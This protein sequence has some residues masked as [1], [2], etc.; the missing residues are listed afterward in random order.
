MSSVKPNDSA[1]RCF[2]PDYTKVFSSTAE[3]RQIASLVN[4]KT[5]QQLR[6]LRSMLVLARNKDIGQRYYMALGADYLSNYVKAYLVGKTSSGALVLAGTPPGVEGRV[7]FSYL[8][9]DCNLLSPSDFKKHR[10]K[11][12]RQGRLVDPQLKLT[13]KQRMEV[14]DD[15]YEVPTIDSAPKEY[16]G[17]IKKLKGDL[18]EMLI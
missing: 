4:G 1:P 3:L 9:N 8:I 5:S 2:T 10:V 11:L 13:K 16:R 15:N 17:K 14:E 7:F 12:M 18:V 6:I